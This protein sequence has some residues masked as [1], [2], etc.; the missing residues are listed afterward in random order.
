ML[1]HI[2][3]F[4]VDFFTNLNAK[5]IFGALVA[6]AG[7][8]MLQMVPGANDPNKGVAY[9]IVGILLG[10][11]GFIIIYYDIAKDKHGGGFDQLDTIAKGYEQKEHEKGKLTGW[12]MPEETFSK[13]PS[14]KDDK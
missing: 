12:H 10:G 6:L 7:I 1:S 5:K 8:W 13:H 9:A 14:D 2:L 3:D 4:L 11:V